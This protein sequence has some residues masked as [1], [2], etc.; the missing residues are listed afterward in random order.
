VFA[1]R[2]T[3]I[4]KRVHEHAATLVD[5]N[6]RIEPGDDVVVHVGERAHDLGVAVAAVLASGGRTA[7]P[8]QLRRDDVSFERKPRRS[9]R[10]VKR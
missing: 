8:V 6:A 1:D 9:G 4:D 2:T 7:R 10:G 5:W 3:A